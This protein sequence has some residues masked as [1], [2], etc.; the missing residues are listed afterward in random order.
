MWQMVAKFDLQ[1]ADC[2]LTGGKLRTAAA[3][4][5]NNCVKNC[6]SLFRLSLSLTEK[7]P[8]QLTEIQGSCRNATHRTFNSYP[9]KVKVALRRS[10]DACQTL[11][12]VYLRRENHTLWNGFLVWHKEVQTLDLSR[13]NLFCLYLSTW[14][15]RE[16]QQ[17]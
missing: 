7:I 17:N 12:F 2:D 1:G 16:K 14:F 8:D 4:Y 9:V 3:M 6:K 5:S 13:G 11:K 10:G 15:R